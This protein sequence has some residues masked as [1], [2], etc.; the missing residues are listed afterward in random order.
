MRE[1]H[2]CLGD[3]KVT[4]LVK[5]GRDA[6]VKKRDTIDRERLDVQRGISSMGMRFNLE[7]NAEA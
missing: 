7:V 6:A 4:K 3:M 1:R 5:S 2:T